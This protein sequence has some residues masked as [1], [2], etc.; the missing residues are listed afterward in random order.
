MNELDWWIASQWEMFKIKEG[1]TG[2]EFNKTDKE[3]NVLTVDRTQKWNKLRAKTDLKEMYIVRYADDF[4]LFCRDYATAKKV[5]CATKLWLAENLHLQTSGEKSGITNLR[6]NYTTFL[7]IKFKVVPKGS[8]WVIRSHMA[9]K[10]KAKVIKKLKGRMII[11]V[12]YVAYEYPKYKRREVNKYVRKYSDIENCISYDVMKYM[13]ENAH[14]YP[15]LEMAD[16]ALSRYIAQKG[17]CA[18]THN[19]LSISDMVCVHIKPC[20]GERNDTY[21]NLI[22]LSKEVSELVGATNPVKIGKLLKDLQLTEEMKDK[23]NKLRKHRELEEI[24]F[25]DYIGTKK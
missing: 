6:K 7:G 5:M 18:V 4:K 23:I 15:T 13:M 19:A 12:G 10:S 22:I 9:D 2:L 8:K 25:E 14:L 3:G 17:K 21:R 24:Q 1:K 20:K 11:P 16:N